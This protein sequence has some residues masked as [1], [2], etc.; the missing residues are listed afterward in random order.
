MRN[1]NP[2]FRNEAFSRPQFGTGQEVMTVSGTV[3]KSLFLLFLV[4]LSSLSTFLYLALT[5]KFQ[6]VGLFAMAGT[7][8]AFVVGLIASFRPQ[9]CSFLAPLYAVFQ[10]LAIGAVTTLLSLK[11]SGIAI[12]AVG[13]SFGVAGAML[14]GYK[15]G[16]IRV[17]ERFRAIVVAA[18]MGI[19]FTYLATWLLGF[20][21]IQLPFLRGG[22]FG[23]IFSLIV[24]GV[25]ALNLVLDF[26]NIEQ[27]AA[28]GAP[29]HYEWFAAFGL[30]VTLVWMY[31]EILRLL[32]IL[33]GSDD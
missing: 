15:F 19:F 13:L 25:A 26:D 2:V 16:I 4:V 20:F 31:W 27:G 7:G 14:A 12:Q 3:N 23:I 24:I 30:M 22:M 8:I 29:A 18:T 17:T 32:S 10:G 6:T 11:Y 21:G 9:N 28:N 1:S 5:H 33:R